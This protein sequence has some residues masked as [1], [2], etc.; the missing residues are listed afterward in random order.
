MFKVLGG[1][2]LRKVTF[3]PAITHL[4]VFLMTGIRLNVITGIR[5]NVITS[6]RLFVITYNNTD[7]DF[8]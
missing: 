1:E 6:I 7:D 5:L 4:R 2:G 8:R 3:I